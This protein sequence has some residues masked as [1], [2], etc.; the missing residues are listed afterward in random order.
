MRHTFVFVALLL[1][2]SFVLAA[3]VVCPEMNA[4]QRWAGYLSWMGFLKIMGVVALASGFVIFFY[5]FLKLA[6]DTLW[7]MIRDIADV[8]VYIVSFALL[9]A[10]AWTPAEYQLWPVLGGCI[11]FGASVQFTIWLRKIKGDSPVGVFGLYTLVWG[12][13]AIYY[14]MP[15]VAFMAVG[16]FVGLLGFSVVVTPLCYSFGF[17]R[18]EDIAATTAAAIMMLA[19][20]VAA[21][22]FYPDA[23]Q[24]IKVFETGVFW[25]GSFVGFIGLLILS[26]EWYVASKKTSYAWIQFVTLSCYIA[27]VAIGMTFNINALAGMAGTFLV[28]YVAAKLI[29]I[30]TASAMG[31][32]LKVMLIGGLFSGVWFIASQHQDVIKTYLTTTLQT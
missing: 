32:G 30:K 12:A 19:A 24:A 10:G 16:A 21:Y 11:L 3:D 23:I 17:K 26:N 4:L 7:D 27:G 9:I 28:F 6:W 13:V 14:G 18:E 5:G 1:F 8:L 22:I 29:E 31:F 25:L 20:Y 2:S 15:E